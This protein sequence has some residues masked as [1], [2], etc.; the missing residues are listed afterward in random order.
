M[1]I[2][3]ATINTI[4]QYNCDIFSDPEYSSNIYIKITII[5]NFNSN[6][7][8]LPLNIQYYGDLNQ[9]E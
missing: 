3:T 5:L 7:K 9:G 1:I 4:L 6:F 2:P 8:F